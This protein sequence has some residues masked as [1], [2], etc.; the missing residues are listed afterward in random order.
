MNET[1]AKSSFKTAV[2]V[3]ALVPLIILAIAITV[4]TSISMKNNMVGQV[5][6]DLSDLAYTSMTTF[7]TAI[8]GDYKMVDGKLMKGQAT[9]SGHYSSLKMQT[10]R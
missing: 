10:A 6:D 9:L 1:K 8:P 5:K 2:L 4:I 3:A 7:E